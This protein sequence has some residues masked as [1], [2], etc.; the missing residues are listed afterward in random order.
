MILDRYGYTIRS[1][2]EFIIWLLYLNLFTFILCFTCII[3]PTYIYPNSE[4]FSSYAMKEYYRINHIPISNQSSEQCTLTDSQCQALGIPLSNQ[5]DEWNST[6][7]SDSF[8]AGSC[9][10]LHTDAFFVNS[11]RENDWTEFLID[12]TDGTVS[13]VTELHLIDRNHLII[14]ISNSHPFIYWLLSKLNKLG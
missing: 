11:S 2:F 12:L 5:T 4:D 14:G 3:M 7:L 10:S 8:T 1:Y 13:G 6:C 9:C